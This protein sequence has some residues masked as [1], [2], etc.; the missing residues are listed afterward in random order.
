MLLNQM[1]AAA[2]AAAMEEGLVGIRVVVEGRC[3][4]EQAREGGVVGG[5]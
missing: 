4:I 2:A 5:L 3:V 1:A